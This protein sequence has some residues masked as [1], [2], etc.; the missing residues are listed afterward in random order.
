MPRPVLALPWGSKSMS[1]TRFPDPAFL[2]DDGKDARVCRADAGRIA[3]D[4][5][6]K[7]C[8]QNLHGSPVQVAARFRKDPKGWDATLRA[9]STLCPPGSIPRLRSY[10]SKITICC[11]YLSRPPLYLVGLARVQ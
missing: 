3:D 2:I 10:P 9:S 6:I 8:R 4:R 7:R 11:G 1:R 5:A